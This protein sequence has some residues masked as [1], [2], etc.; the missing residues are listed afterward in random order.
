VSAYVIQPQKNLEELVCK[1]HE[2]RSFRVEGS[3][4]TGPGVG[5]IVRSSREPFSSHGGL[6]IIQTHPN[7]RSHHVL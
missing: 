2:R 1:A 3:G 4:L 7:A 5:F 6:G